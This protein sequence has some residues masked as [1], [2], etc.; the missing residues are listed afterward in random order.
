[1]RDRKLRIAGALHVLLVISA[2]L[3][4]SVSAHP[5]RGPHEHVRISATTAN[6]G[7]S[8]GLKWVASYH[9]AAKPHRDPPALRHLAIRLPRGTRYDTSVPGRCSASDQELML[10]GEAACPASSRVGR[11][12]ASLKVL[13]GGAMTY[14]GIDFNADHQLIELFEADGRPVGV[15]RTHAHGRVLRGPVPT[16]LTGGNPPS[17]CP[18]DQMVLLSNTINIHALSRGHGSARRNFATTPATCPRSAHWRTRVR[19][20]YAD[21]SVDRVVTRQPCNDAVRGR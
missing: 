19:F 2:L 11:S 8:T 20:H 13:G 3:A 1:V 18:S 12:Q 7:A 6:P 17:G 16:C 21:G 5:G 14:K 4:L 9:S 15:I 10:V